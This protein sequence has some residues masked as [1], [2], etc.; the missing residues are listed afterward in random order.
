M[1]RALTCCFTAPPQ[2]LRP[3]TVSYPPRFEQAPEISA[4]A[5]LRLNPDSASDASVGSAIDGGSRDEE[6]AA[7]NGRGGAAASMFLLTTE[8]DH[9]PPQQAPAV[10]TT[11]S[12]SVGA[13]SSA[14]RNSTLSAGAAVSRST[15]SQLMTS[16]DPPHAAG[17]SSGDEAA[18]ARDLSPS[19]SGGTS[20][21]THSHATSAAPPASLASRISLFSILRTRTDDDGNTDADRGS[22]G[23]SAAVAAT[24]G[25]SAAQTLSPERTLSAT[26]SQPRTASQRVAVRDA[27][28]QA[29]IR[30]RAE[31]Q[32]RLGRL[33]YEGEEHDRS[34]DE[35]AETADLEAD[36]AADMVS[37]L[38]AG[39][40]VVPPSDRSDSPESAEVE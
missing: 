21:S 31:R 18:R 25:F 17:M 22:I 2:A 39:Q 29:A 32:Q 4:M 40:P 28:Q 26:Q 7:G 5:P 15:D 34:T 36:L 12:S 33:L 37:A 27:V 6:G 1:L 8:L 19:D 13:F 30:R 10:V 23:S 38:S 9:G 11:N 20:N 16:T 24:G 3:T 14:G 35:N